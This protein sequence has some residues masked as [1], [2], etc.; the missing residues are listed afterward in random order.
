MYLLKSP[1]ENDGVPLGFVERR[2]LQQAERGVSGVIV[3]LNQQDLDVG[4]RLRTESTRL[5]RMRWL[6]SMLRLEKGH[7]G[8]E[9]P[10]VYWVVARNPDTKVLQG[11]ADLGCEAYAIGF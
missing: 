11:C 3:G 8:W 5:Y 10:V 1:D 9:D 6:T 7:P 4:P 2:Q